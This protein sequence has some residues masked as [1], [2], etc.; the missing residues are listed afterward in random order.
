ML[1]WS[2]VKKQT[3]GIAP[4]KL[5]SNRNNHKVYAL[6]ACLNHDHRLAVGVDLVLYAG[7]IHPYF[8]GRGDCSCSGEIDSR[9]TGLSRRERKIMKNNIQEALRNDSQQIVEDAQTL[10]E[11]TADIAGEKVA[12]ARKR[13]KEIVERV[14]ECGKETWG[15]VSEKAMAGAKATDQTIRDNP[16]QSLGVAFG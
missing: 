11:A 13:I 16:Y 2:I 4:A 15:S 3:G 1:F 5:Y 9:T 6:R 7:R 8:I 14:A 10:I 12:E